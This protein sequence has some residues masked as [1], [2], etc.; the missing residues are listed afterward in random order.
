MYEESKKRAYENY[1]KR[2]KEK[3]KKRKLISVTDDE[4]EIVQRV[5]VAYRKILQFKNRKKL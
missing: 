1:K 2:E 5:I 3:G 4:Y